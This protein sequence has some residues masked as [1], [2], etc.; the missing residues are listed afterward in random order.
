MG[1]ELAARAVGTG[2]A[3]LPE[4]SISVLCAD[5]SVFSPNKSLAAVPRCSP[6]W[7][8]HARECF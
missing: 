6:L 8:S 3:R 4:S 7:H 1:S 2:G 5:D